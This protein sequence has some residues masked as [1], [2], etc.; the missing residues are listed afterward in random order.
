GLD[1]VAAVRHPAQRPF[2][3]GELLGRTA[4]RGEPG[5]RRLHDGAQ[6]VQVAQEA[7]VGA[8][9]ELPP[10]H[11]AVE[12][13][14]VGAG[15][16]VGAEL[17]LGADEPLGGEHL[18]GLAQRGG[19]DAEAFAQRVHVEGAA[20]PDLPAED[21]RSERLDGL[22]VQAPASV[23][24]SHAESFTM[25]HPPSTTTHAPVT[26]EASAEARKAI[27]DATSSGAPNRPR[28]VALTLSALPSPSTRSQ[29]GV[30]IG[31]GITALT[32]TAGPYSTASCRVSA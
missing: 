20:F 3:R 30:M 14:P 17:G 11:V 23:R 27:T 16:H 13:A 6:L 29:A 28:T 15:P 1:R 7:G 9:G 5:D 4:E 25:L 22:A 18:H 21:H 31:P 26:N 8:A 32:R 2:Q 10:D 12:Q 19:A 24:A